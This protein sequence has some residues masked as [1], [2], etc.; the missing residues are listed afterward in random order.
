MAT[1]AMAGCTQPSIAAGSATT[2]PRWPPMLAAKPRCGVPV[3]ESGE[4]P[5]MPDSLD[6][7]DGTMFGK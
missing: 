4:L 3:H 7:Q 2:V 5:V 6:S 1:A